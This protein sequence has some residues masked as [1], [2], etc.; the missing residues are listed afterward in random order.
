MLEPRGLYAAPDDVEWQLLV[1]DI[2]GVP[3]LARILRGLQPGQRAE[4]VVVLTDADDE[5]PLPSA[6][7][8]AVQWQVVEH[9]ADICD[10]LTAAVVDRELP[11]TR[12]GTCGSPARPGPAGPCAVTC[13]ASWDGRRATSTP[14]ATGRSTPRRGTR[15]TRRSPTR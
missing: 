13:A 3:A 9:E 12:A 11:P 2:T 5:I 10:A 6:G 1:A 7:D 8:V 4:A 14:A 15:A